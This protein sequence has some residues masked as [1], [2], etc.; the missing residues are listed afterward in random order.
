[1]TGPKVL[2]LGWKRATLGKICDIQTGKKDVNEG[3]PKGKYLFYTCAAE[4][5]RS[6]VYSFEGESILL[7]GNGANVGMAFYY[8]GKFEAYQRTYVRNNFS[9]SGKYVLYYFLS[10]WR[11]HV[12]GKQYG[13]ATNY[14]RLGNLTSF[15]LAIPPRPEQEHIVSRIEELFT[16]LEAGVAE[17]RNAKAQLKRYR[18][19]VLKS[20]VEGELTR[21][22]REAHQS[23][24]EPA[25]TLLA[26]IL[27]E[28]RK[29][30]EAEGGKGKYKEPV[31]S[32]TNDLPELPDGWLWTTVEQL[33]NVQTG[34]TP[35]RS[36]PKYWTDGTIPWVTSGALNNLYVNEANEFITELALKET[37]TKIFPKHTLL[38]A[39]YG[40]G[41]TRGKISEL[42]ID[43]ATNQAIAAL[44]FDGVASDVR[45]Y[46][47]L[48]FLDY[49]NEIRRKASGGV[50]PNLNLGMIKEFSHTVATF[51]R[52]TTHI[53]QSRAA[54]VG[55]R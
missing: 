38:V 43:A 6:D 42:M 37:N 48:F 28:R 33:A 35:L 10:F 8:D 36:N 40:E 24:I 17:L 52:T 15:S 27:E 2:P 53:R 3:N 30:W 7:P 50:Q 4:P 21:A 31:S 16:Q 45:P 9:V 23:E 55:G 1:M 12:Q 22:W 54:A 5:T 41:K 25:E 20:A 11:D 34:A 44:I 47:K 49:Y 32:D 13:S 46:V 29:K 18:A 19:A 26:R 51:R 39:M 14:I